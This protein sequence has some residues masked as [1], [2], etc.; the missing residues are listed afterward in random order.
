MKNRY[1]FWGLIVLF[2]SCQ[3]SKTEG[4]TLAV[5]PYKEQL[6]EVIVLG[7]IHDGHLTEKEYD[8][9]V[10]KQLIQ[11]I[12]PDFI[13]AEIPPDRFD[14]A[15]NEFLE[16]DTIS[17]ARVK[18][19]PEYVHVIFP[20]TKTMDFEIIP[21]AGWTKPMS[22][23]RNKKLKQI[24]EDPNRKKDWDEYLSAFKLSDSLIKASGHQ[25]DPY[26]INSSEYDSLVEIELSV[27]NDLFNVELGL[28]GWDNINKA[29]YWYINEFLNQHKNE[30]LR[31][32]ITYGA[33]HKGWFLKELKKR[34]DIKL[35]KLKDVIK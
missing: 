26:W 3:N 33:G 29:H 10:L 31:I 21:T 16:L 2:L 9:L 25:F 28:G 8:T 20:L 15:M 32:L 4:P 35:I 11:D 23:D 30:G 24:S 5:E 14:D 22:D 27:Y 13:L 12:N 6:N 18:R 7:T 34:D 1:I 17:E 19:F